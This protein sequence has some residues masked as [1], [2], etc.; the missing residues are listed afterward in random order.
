MENLK[1]AS[2]LNSE[3]LRRKTIKV[4]KKK[5]VE[6]NEYLRNLQ[7]LQAQLDIAQEQRKSLDSAGVNKR[8]KDYE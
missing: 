3:K 4:E 8:Q 6:E 7:Q 2:L 5:L 1:N